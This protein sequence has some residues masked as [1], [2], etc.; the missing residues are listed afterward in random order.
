MEMKEFDVYISLQVQFMS[1][2]RGLSSE[3]NCALQVTKSSDSNA[4]CFY[5]TEGEGFDFISS[6]AEMLVPLSY[7]FTGSVLDLCYK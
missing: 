5:L 3:P 7:L 4:T 2:Q 6:K 1:F